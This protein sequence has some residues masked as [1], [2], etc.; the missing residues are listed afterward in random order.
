MLN[1]PS[2]EVF[3]NVSKCSKNIH[4]ICSKK[5]MAKNHCSQHP[6]TSS[7]KL[8]KAYFDIF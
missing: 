8:K 3:K 7:T 4:E 1:I 5:F 2:R 6:K